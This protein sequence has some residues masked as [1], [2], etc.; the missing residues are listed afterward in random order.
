MT[1]LRWRNR[2]VLAR[3]GGWPAG[4][5]AECERLDVEYPG[6]HFWWLTE[7]VFP[8]WERPAGFAAHLPTAC[9]VGADELRRLPEDGVEREPWV[10]GPDVATVVRKIGFVGERLAERE[11]LR[12]R[13]SA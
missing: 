11:D 13:L 3:R 10:F 7:N 9:L 8:G 4:A 12:E 1:D 6:W 2:R 5:L